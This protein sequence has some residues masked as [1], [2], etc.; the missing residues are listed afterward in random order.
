MSNPWPI[1]FLA[2]ACT[3]PSQELM[4][5]GHPDDD[6]LVARE[7]QFIPE[8]NAV[9]HAMDEGDAWRTVILAR[10]FNRELEHLLKTSATAEKQL[11]FMVM[12]DD[13]SLA[14]FAHDEVPLEKN[15]GDD[16][17]AMRIVIGL[18]RRH[19]QAAVAAGNRAMRNFSSGDFIAAALCN[20]VLYDGKG[21]GGGYLPDYRVPRRQFSRGHFPQ[22]AKLLSHPVALSSPLLFKLYAVHCDVLLRCI[23]DRGNPAAFLRQLWDGELRHQRPLP[24]SFAMALGLSPDDPMALQAWYEQNAIRA[25]RHGLRRM[26]SEDTARHLRRLLSVPVVDASAEGGIRHIALADLPDRMADYHLDNSALDAMLRQL[27]R[28]QADAPPLLRSALAKYRLAILALSAGRLRQFRDL[29]PEADRDFSSALRRQ[30]R[31]GQLL[32]EVIAADATEADFI[33]NS[34]WE[35]AIIHLEHNRQPIDEAI[36]L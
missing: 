30:Q 9:V 28:Y 23:E 16:S 10:R 18:L 11:H 12:E 7:R 26:D 3:L 31:A 15:E 36:G 33:R 2:L 13:F 1:L 22:C 4:L 27:A 35:S 32:D 29:L 21:V 24:E 19:A 8:M 34:V 17:R 20:R 25:V 14:R 6:T 5:S